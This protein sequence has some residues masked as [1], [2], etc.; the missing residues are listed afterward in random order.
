M[1]RHATELAVSLHL[2]C[3]DVLALVR[4]GPRTQGL[5]GHAQGQQRGLTL[6][7]SYYNDGLNFNGGIPVNDARGID[8]VEVVNLYHSFSF[9]G[10]SA[11]V[12]VSRCSCRNAP[13]A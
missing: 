6:T 4:A 2:G 8:N 3:T 11:N 7:W 1:A 10:C 13:H 5:C 9:F 12:R